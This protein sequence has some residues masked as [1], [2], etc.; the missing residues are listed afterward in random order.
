MFR[1]LGGGDGDPKRRHPG[2]L[3]RSHA[4][5]VRAGYYLA[6]PVHHRAGTAG[7]GR[8]CPAPGGPGNGAPR[9]RALRRQEGEALRAPQRQRLSVP[10]GAIALLED[11][12][13]T[14]CADYVV[15]LQFN[16]AW[17]KVRLHLRDVQS[18]PGRDPAPARSPWL[19]HRPVAHPLARDPAASTATARLLSGREPMKRGT[20][21]HPKT[22]A[23]AQQLGIEEWGAVGILE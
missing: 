3:E 1:V 9:P 13:G 17:V 6:G 19:D 15:P 11:R 20:I 2:G 21:D 12:P 8:A 22:L 4:G 14:R 16:R 10:R 5:P 7:A 23:L 18:R